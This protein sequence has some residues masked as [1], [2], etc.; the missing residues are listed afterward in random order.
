MFFIREKKT[1]NQKSQKCVSF[2]PKFLRFS[3]C[4]LQRQCFADIRRE[5]FFSE[6]FSR[7]QVKNICDIVVE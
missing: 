4:S 7:K 1:S 2:A 3:A 5:K 6:S